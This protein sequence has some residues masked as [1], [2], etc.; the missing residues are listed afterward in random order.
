[1]TPEQKQLLSVSRK[2]LD[3]MHVAEK[4]ILGD[5]G[6]AWCAFWD[7]L[8][9]ITGAEQVNDWGKHWTD[10]R[11]LLSATPEQRAQAIETIFS[12]QNQTQEINHE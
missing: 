9:D 8:C 1:M 6:D 11:I 10:P 12:N 5:D 7:A 3:L 4:E 2:S